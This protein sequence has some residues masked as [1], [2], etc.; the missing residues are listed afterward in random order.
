MSR[1]YEQ[2][3]NKSNEKVKKKKNVWSLYRKIIFLILFAIA[4]LSFLVFYV[5]KYFELPDEALIIP[6]SLED[7]KTLC[8]IFTKYATDNRKKLIFVYSYLYIWKSSFGLPGSI[9]FNLLGG[10]LFGEISVPLVIILSSVGASNCYILSKLCIGSL[11][12]YYAH[13][14]IKSLE[15][16]IKKHENNL[17]YY[18][19]FIR[20]FP[21]VPN[22]FVNIASPLIKIKFFP[23]FFLS[24][25]I[26]LLSYNIVTTQAGF[27][28]MSLNSTKDI[29]N[30]KFFI[31]VLPL[32]LLALIPPIFGN[33]IKGY[34]K[35]EKGN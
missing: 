8:N 33:K 2:I 16:K 32:S 11:L 26:G 22:W 5:K 23:H 19:L 10:A 35:K 7:A 24:N 17:F 21:I 31:N 6:K 29:I 14:K 9:V 13:D 20:L 25:L 28:L 4:T 3:I 1:T 34:F 18:L 30:A 12:D 15:N 27:I